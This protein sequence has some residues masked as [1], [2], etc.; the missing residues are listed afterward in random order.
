[1]D[2]T[3]TLE[4]LDLHFHDSPREALLR[5]NNASARET[6]FLSPEK[7]DKM[8]ASALVATF[9]GPQAAF[10]L[11]FEHTND[12][13]GGHFRW[14]RSRFD[15]FVYIDRVVVAEGCRRY[16]YGAM[17]YADLFARA[18]ALGHTDV[19]CEVNFEPPNPAS[20]KFHVAH[21]FEEVGRA[22]IDNGA[23]T[24]RY[25]RRCR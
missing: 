16:G 18:A 11:A 13:D 25:L 20:D 1:M 4:V 6:S 10:L 22:T 12:Y 17:L 24:V 9:I 19:V 7:F 2:A 21:G 15:K 8:I 5:V 14:F 23:K 3:M